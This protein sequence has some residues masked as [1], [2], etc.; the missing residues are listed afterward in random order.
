MQAVIDGK[1]VT[2]Q[3]WNDETCCV[4]LAAGL[5]HLRKSDGTLHTLI[6]SDG[7]MQGQ[8]WVTVRET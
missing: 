5:L 1:K 2:R 4:F 8:D 7:D 3:A 6:V